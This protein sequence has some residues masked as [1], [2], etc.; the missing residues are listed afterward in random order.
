MKYIKR[1]V[2]FI[3]LWKIT[4]GN[5]FLKIS[6]CKDYWK[7]RLVDER[8]EMVKQS[9]FYWEIQA[10]YMF[11]YWYISRVPIWSLLSSLISICKNCESFHKPLPN[12][13]L[14]FLLCVSILRR[15]G[16]RWEGRAWQWV[17]SVCLRCP[18][19]KR[20]IEF[21]FTYIEA[22]KNIWMCDL[23]SVHGKHDF[24]RNMVRYNL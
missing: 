3:S 12:N 20:L 24:D 13:W 23:D 22:H 14:K 10:N 5:W 15:K 4:T 19:E 8:A 18:F 2:C 16:T 9:K 21:D 7:E 17:T 1:L 6:R 11:G